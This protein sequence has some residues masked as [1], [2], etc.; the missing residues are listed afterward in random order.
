MLGCRITMYGPAVYELQIQGRLDKSWI[1][2][3]Q[4]ET[5]S[6]VD[7]TDSGPVSVLTSTFVDQAALRGMLDRIYNLNLPLI[8][9]RHIGNA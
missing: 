2:Q 5:I 3:M 6:V 9:V 4:I 8:S 1:A 7:E